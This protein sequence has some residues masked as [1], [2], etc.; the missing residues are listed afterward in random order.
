MATAT[1]PNAELVMTGETEKI[2]RSRQP[3]VDRAMNLFE[4]LACSRSGLTLSELSRK[5]SLPKSTTHYLIHTLETR[6]YLQRTV[7]GRHA[8]GLRFARL[9]AASTAEMDFCKEAKPY[10]RQLA[11]RLGLTTA[12]TALR[13]AEAVVIAIGAAAQVGGGGVWIGRHVDLH[14]TA[15]GKALIATMSDEELGEVFGGREFAH[16]TS[17]TILSLS[18]LK[19]DLAEVR[20]CGYSVNDEEY[21][22]G[23][24]AVAAPIFD[25]LGVVVSAVSVRGSCRQIPS[26]QLPHLGHEMIRASRELSALLAAH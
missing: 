10:L 17:K 9:A 20:A 18:A 4:L 2:L 5:L 22:Q 13:G 16:F 6:G 24:R 23:V 14:C 15:Q 7:D 3:A 1:A 11:V 21:Y 26:D 19:A 25:S 12:L 8:L